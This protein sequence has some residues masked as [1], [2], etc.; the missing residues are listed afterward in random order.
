M[1]EDFEL[2]M[3]QWLSMWYHA[4]LTLML[5][6]V[7]ARTSVQMGGLIFI[8]IVNAIFNAILFGIYF[9]LLEETR[10]RQNEFQ[11]QL[12]KANTAMGNLTLPAS[13]K[14]DV[15]N[16]ILQTHETKTQQQ[17]YVQF[18]DSMPPSKNVG[19]NSLNFKKVLYLSESMLLLRINMRDAHRQRYRQLRVSDIDDPNAERVDLDKGEKDFKRLIKTI[20]LG[21]KIQH[22]QPEEVVIMQSDTIFNDNGD[23]NE[24]KAYFYIILNGD[25]KVSSLKFGSHAKKAGKKKRDGESQDGGSLVLRGSGG[26]GDRYLEN[27]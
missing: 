4:A 19:I 11:S 5:V 2:F 10:R 16:Y 13:L 25:F 26:P 21:L 24:S 3:F 7:T 14:D 20:T 22:V 23:F 8:Y 27:S 15:R 12:D 1:R 18:A 17:E 9:D 6:E